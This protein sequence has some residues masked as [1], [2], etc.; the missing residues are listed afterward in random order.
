VH[1]IE[2]LNCHYGVLQE[3]CLDM[4][5]VE[6][7]EIVHPKGVPFVCVMHITM[8]VLVIYLLV[9]NITHS[10]SSTKD[11]KIMKG[12]LMSKVAIH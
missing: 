5:C 1:D 9:S 3:I 7:N 8:C 2:E 4:A 12:K 10:S 11:K 6:W